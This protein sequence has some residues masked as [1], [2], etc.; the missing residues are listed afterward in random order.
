MAQKGVY[1]FAGFATNSAFLNHGIVSFLKRIASRQGL[2]LE[3][4]LFQVVI[5]KLP[6]NSDSAL[7]KFAFSFEN[8][9]STNTFSADTIGCEFY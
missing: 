6:T 7:Q 9:L 3:P 2:N 4:M 1:Y 8:C 5:N